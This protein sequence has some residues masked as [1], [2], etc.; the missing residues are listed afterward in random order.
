M[1]P[2]QQAT[3][4]Y[5]TTAGQLATTPTYIAYSSS[6]T[7]TTNPVLQETPAAAGNSYGIAV[8]G[9]GNV[10]VSSTKTANFGMEVYQTSG[11]GASS[12]ATGIAQIGT[13]IP[14][15]AAT[16][17]N[18]L[19]NYAFV[20]TNRYPSTDGDS[21]VWIG[22]YG[23]NSIARVYG[24]AG[25]SILA[26]TPCVASGTS[27]C[28]PYTTTLGLNNVY[29]STIDSTGAVWAGSQSGSLMQI[30]GVGAPSFPLLQS[31]HPGVMP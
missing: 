3:S 14:G 11:A 7:P 15:A 1:I 19:I 26:Y 30:F 23:N 22:N 16:T 24:T 12:P 5:N 10:W 8:D 17:T 6:S 27:N 13:I 29:Y 25:T 4:T 31:G 28:A 21:A 9:S 2:N 20:A 18:G